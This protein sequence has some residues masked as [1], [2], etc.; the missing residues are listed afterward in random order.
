MIELDQNFVFIFA[1]FIWRL[2]CCQVEIVNSYLCKLMCIL[3]SIEGHVCIMY[4]QV[5][6][7]DNLLGSG[8]HE[9]CM[10]YSVNN[11]MQ[12]K[13]TLSTILLKNYTTYI[14]LGTMDGFRIF[15]PE[16]V[17]MK[18][19]AKQVVLPSKSSLTPIRQFSKSL[20]TNVKFVKYLP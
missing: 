13:T 20:T 8:H 14:L 17:W 6:T 9:M 11:S 7:Y 3:T 12:I 19:P 15:C 10:I 2:F 1:A 16:I 4:M 18:K 5:R